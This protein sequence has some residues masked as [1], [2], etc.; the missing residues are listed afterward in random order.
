MPGRPVNWSEFEY[1]IL[2]ISEPSI[3]DHLTYLKH[4]EFEI[5]NIIPL[6]TS[7]NFPPSEF[8]IWN[9]SI[10]S[11]GLHELLQYYIFFD[12]VDYFSDVPDYYYYEV[13]RLLSE[14]IL[15][16]QKWERRVNTLEILSQNRNS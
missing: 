7:S 16:T 13:K 14:L 15:Y 1:A 5:Q 3:F 6:P 2:P 12:S 4:L 9:Y 11:Q 10:L 8:E